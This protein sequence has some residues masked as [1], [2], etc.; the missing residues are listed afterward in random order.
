MTFET[1][2]IKFAP[3]IKLS[4]TVDI[5]IGYYFVQKAPCGRIPFAHFNRNNPCVVVTLI[6][7]W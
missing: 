6:F 3:S 5:I 2:G 4:N 1:K 7:Y